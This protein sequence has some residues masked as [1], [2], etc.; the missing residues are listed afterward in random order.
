[1]AGMSKNARVSN[2]SEK[3]VIVHNY[4]TTKDMVV[5]TIEDVRMC[6]IFPKTGSKSKVVIAE[7]KNGLYFTDQSYVNTPLLDPYRQY[8][9]DPVAT[10][11]KE[12]I[13]GIVNFK[14]PNFEH[15]RAYYNNR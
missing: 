5:A 15:L 12:E 3:N 6:D 10:V 14:L 4:G 11:V 8:M 13:D 1:M 9:R 7:D 2:K